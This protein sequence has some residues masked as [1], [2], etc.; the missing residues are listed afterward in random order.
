MLQDSKCSNDNNTPLKRKKKQKQGGFLQAKNQP[1]KNNTETVICWD[2]FDS[3]CSKY[4]YSLS[5]SCKLWAKVWSSRT[6]KS[7]HTVW[8][9]KAKR[10]RMRRKEGEKKRKNIN[11]DTWAPK[12]R[13]CPAQ[14]KV[15]AQGTHL[16]PA[17]QPWNAH[18][19]AVHS[20]SLCSLPCRLWTRPAFLTPS[21]VPCTCLL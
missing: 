5:C 11:A 12:Q 4:C 13:H 18:R 20:Q 14:T 17:P 8:G 2:T 21:Y 10:M 15:S 9:N 1:H 6:A 16:C 3:I 7:R 19:W